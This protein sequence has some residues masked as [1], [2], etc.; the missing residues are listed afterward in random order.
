[1]LLTRTKSPKTL[2]IPTKAG[3]KIKT[4][5]TCD[6]SFTNNSC[7]QLKSTFWGHSAPDTLT[8]PLQGVLGPCAPNKKGAPKGELTLRTRVITHGSKGE[9]TLRTRV[10]THGSKGE[11]ALRGS[12]LFG[13]HGLNTHCQYVCCIRDCFY[14]NTSTLSPLICLN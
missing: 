14:N 3:D 10:I 2:S 11:L 5:L 8:L 7:R 4:V 13:A 6:A 12:F 9:L 1:M